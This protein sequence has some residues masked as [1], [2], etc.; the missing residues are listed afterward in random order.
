M[1]FLSTVAVA[2][3]AASVTPTGARADPCDAFVASNN[4]LLQFSTSPAIV[5]GA[6]VLGCYASFAITPTTMATQVASIKTYFNL[7]PYLDLAKNSSTPYFESKVDLFAT[8]DAIAANASIT[9]E[10]DFQSQVQAAIVSLN[11]GGVVYESTCFGFANLFQPFVIDAKFSAGAKPT[12]YVRGSNADRTD[13][14]YSEPESITLDPSMVSRITPLMAKVWN[15]GTNGGP[16]QYVGYT[17]AKI[18]GVDAVTYIQTVADRSTA[19]SHSPDARFNSVLPSSAWSMS[20]FAFVLKDGSLYRTNS[21]AYG[22]DWYWDYELVSPTGETVTLSKV[23]WAGYVNTEYNLTS[24]TWY[25]ST[26]CLWDTNTTSTSA[27]ASQLSASHTTE[28]TVQQRLGAAATNSSTQPFNIFAQQVFYDVVTF[29]LLDDG[30]TGVFSLRDFEPIQTVGYIDFI[31]TITTGLRSLASAGASRL[32][33]DLSGNPGSSPTSDDSCM[34]DFLLNYLMGNTSSAPIFDVRLSGTYA[35]LIQHADAPAAANLWFLTFSD[36]DLLPD[37]G[38]PSILNHSRAL[39]RG[40]TSESFSDTFTPNCSD[41]FYLT[42]QF[43]QLD[44]KWSPNAI[45]IVTDGLCA[46][47]CGLFVRAMRDQ[48]NV[49]TLVTGGAAG[50]AFPPSSAE[51]AGVALFDFISYEANRLALSTNYSM[52]DNPDGWP[53]DQLPLQVKAALPLWEPYSAQGAGGR[54]IPVAWVSQ[55]ADHYLDVANVSDK[56]T[57]WAAAASIL[58]N[59]THSSAGPR[60]HAPSLTVAV[61]AAV[62]LLAHCLLAGL[63]N[64]PPRTSDFWVTRFADSRVGDDDARGVLGAKRKRTAIAQELI[65]CPDILFLSSSVHAVTETL[66][67]DAVHSGHIVVATINQPSWAQLSLFNKVVFLAAGVVAYFG[68]PRTAARYPCQPELGRFFFMDLLTVDH[69]KTEEDVVKDL[70]HV[71]CIKAAYKYRPHPAQAL[72]GAPFS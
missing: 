11:D 67:R 5:T 24:T 25:H 31:L 10:F 20:N 55:D 42:N 26:L 41:W 34:G 52:T 22:M 30:K 38:G 14:L 13:L 49:T 9:T 47:L 29:H 35:S 6:D 28:R 21:V 2:I 68:P 60:L 16:A 1:R 18:N 71:A 3:T 40:G 45:A 8:L 51:S 64:P 15:N 70:G 66:R 63:S 58:A 12:I 65:G 27:K 37:H 39:T 19:S 53:S 54:D 56:A 44:T 57:V 46:G 61:A 33:I 36:K 72:P 17:V 23:P 43:P 50:S 7:Y 32:L 59:A 4:F 48:Y 69:S 62:A